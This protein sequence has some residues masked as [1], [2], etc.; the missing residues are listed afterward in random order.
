MRIEKVLAQR[1][2][3]RRVGKRSKL[4]IRC[5]IPVL[6]LATS[7]AAWGFMTDFSERVNELFAAHDEI[8]LKEE[9]DP[10]EHLTPGDYIVKRAWVDNVGDVDCYVRVMCTFS[11]DDAL[12]FASL[13]LGADGWSAPD[14]DGWMHYAYP[15][16]PGTSTPCA[17]NGVTIAGDASPA[18]MKPFDIFILAE[19]VQALGYDTPEEAFAAIAGSQSEATDDNEAGDGDEGLEEDQGDE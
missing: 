11:D 14:A 10:P 6:I 15:L 12:A 17:L 3:M 16:A 18:S 8:E 7:I 13:D 4:V 9:F 2:L 5:A 19:S 1:T